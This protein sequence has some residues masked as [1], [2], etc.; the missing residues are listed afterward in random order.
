MREKVIIG[1]S[2]L[3]SIIEEAVRDVLSEGTDDKQFRIRE[4]AIRALV[5]G[6][7]DEIRTDDSKPYVIWV[8]VNRV[9]CYKDE[10]A[11]RGIL[12]R[13]IRPDRMNLTVNVKS[14]T[15]G[16]NYYCEVILPAYTHC[17]LFRE[18]LMREDSAE[19]KTQMKRRK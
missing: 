4:I 6:G 16:I 2:M 19:L 15:M 7:Y 12:N 3:R 18:S 5:K 17:G 13:A 1:E 8:S 10:E 9:N 11:I 14:D